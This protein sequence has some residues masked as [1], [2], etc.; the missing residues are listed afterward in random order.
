M[1]LIAFVEAEI[2]PK[3]EDNGQREA[4][5]LMLMAAIRRQVNTGTLE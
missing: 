4:Y 1:T 2:L 5:V 3:L